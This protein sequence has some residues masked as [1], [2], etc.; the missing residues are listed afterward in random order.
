MLKEPLFLEAPR[1]VLA[2]RPFIRVLPGGAKVRVSVEVLVSADSADDAEF[3]IVLAR[4]RN[5]TYPGWA[6][7]S[8]VLTR[9]ADTGGITRIRAFLRSDPNMYIQFRP[10]SD[11]RSLLDVV[12]Y[13][14]YLI[15]SLP[16]PF[17]IERLMTMPLNDALNAA[18]ASFPRAYF[19]P[20]PALY[21]DNRA[22]IA[23]IRARLPGLTFADDGAIDKSGNYVL[24]KTGEPQTGGRGLNSSGFAKWVIDGILRP[25]TG[26]RIDIAAA[27]AP[28]GDR[29]NSF[30]AVFEES[31]DPFFGLDWIRNLASA[32]G[33][34]LLS[35]A[36]GAIDEFEVRTW[37]FPSL[38][39]RDKT[40]NKA[41]GA[42]PSGSTESYAGFMKD[43]GFNIDGLRPLLYTLAVD[44]PARFYLAAVNDASGPRPS[45][46][47]YF[48]I[49][50]LVPYFNEMGNFNIAVFESAAENT[51]DFFSTRYPSDVFVNLVRIPFGSSFDP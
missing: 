33:T 2:M 17:S 27:K 36:F 15:R 28:F 31:R 38:I 24:I 39:R 49:A 16:I 26:E 6:Q 46:R 47:Q 9:R 22:L 51:F 40:G 3:G 19:E 48:H 37:H 44:E 14:A 29:G 10:L 30:T 25:V 41:R 5:K 23:A 12:V 43:A 11:D 35:P 32:A 4:E 21:Q 7:G 45:L 34:T 1:K 8:W 42:A 50:I 20:H 18:G 13:N